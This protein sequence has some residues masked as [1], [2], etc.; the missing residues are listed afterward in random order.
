MAASS[1]WPKVWPRFNSARSPCLGLVA[2]DDSGLHLAPTGAPHAARAPAS[3]AASAGA[4]R[5]P[6]S[7]RKPRRRAGRISPP[8][9]SPARKSRAG[10]VPSSVDVGQHQAR[11]V[12]GADQVLALGRVDP[13][14]AAD[15]TVD[16]RQQRRRDLHEAARPR[17]RIAAAKPARSPITP[18]PKATH[19]VVAARPSRRSAIRR[20]G[21][22]AA[23]P[24]SPRPPAAPAPPT[25]MP[26]SPARSAAR[27]SAATR[28]VGQHR[29]PRPAQQRRDLG[30]G[31]RQQPGADPHLVGARAKRHPDL[32]IAV[33]CVIRPASSRT[34]PAW[35]ASAAS[36][37]RAMRL[38]R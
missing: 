22:T 11:L 15:R 33:P 37:S 14:L 3:P 18:P 24:W 10:S 28:L 2:R 13:G 21:R 7:R 4:V 16:L 8:R 6:A 31:P 32:V 12:K 9:R 35:A 20:R 30:A 17:R 25:A 23:S 26:P 19:H 38:D 1:A 29:H 34:R 5:A 27:C 36:T